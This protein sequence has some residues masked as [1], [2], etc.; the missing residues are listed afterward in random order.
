MNRPSGFG[1]AETKK[2]LQRAAEI[3]S[4]RP[5]DAN[6]LREIAIEAGISP[7][8]LEQAIAEHQQ[9][10][11]TPVIEKPTWAARLWRWRVLI[12]LMLLLA[13]FAFMRTI[14]RVVP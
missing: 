10:V 4:Q 6:A 5:M 7:A 8:S 2:I 11:A 9:A 12:L 14:E 3:D 13:T 1:D